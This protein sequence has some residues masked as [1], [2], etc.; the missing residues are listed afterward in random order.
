MVRKVSRICFSSSVYLHV[1]KD[2]MEWSS[3]FHSYL[4]TFVVSVMS[5]LV[6]TTVVGVTFVAVDGGRG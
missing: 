1:D 4:T 2:E 6:I 5:A 3:G